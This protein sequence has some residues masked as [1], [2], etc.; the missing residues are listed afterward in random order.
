MSN[1]TNYAPTQTHVNTIDIFFPS[2]AEIPT[3]R[4][5]RPTPWRGVLPAPH[6]ARPLGVAPDGGITPR[7]RATPR[8]D[9]DLSELR[10]SVKK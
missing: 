4:C 5:D 6:A 8:G 1:V 3:L 2:S 9:E 7:G 10:T